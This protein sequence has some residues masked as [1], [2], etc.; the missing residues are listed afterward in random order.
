MAAENKTIT[1]DQLKEH[2]NHENLWLLIQG[3]GKYGGLS[4]LIIPS[5]AWL[6]RPSAFILPDGISDASAVFRSR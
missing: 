3:K 2:K 1:M 4:V 5:M 6:E